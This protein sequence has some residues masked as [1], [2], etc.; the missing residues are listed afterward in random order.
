MNVIPKK[1][2]VR[3]E[4]WARYKYNLTTNIGENDARVT[5]SKEHIALSHKIAAEGMVLLENNGYLPLKPNT[6]V[7]LFG[8]G[9]LDYVKGGGGSGRVYPQ[10][11][12]NLYEG[13]KTKADR[14]SIYEP[15]S[16]Y[17]FDYLSPMA[18]AVTDDRDIVSDEIELPKELII[19]AAKNS[20]V[21]IISIHRFSREGFDRLSEKG[22]FY[23]TDTEQNLI[24]EVTTTFKHTIA[25]LNV[26]GM[27]DVSWLKG[28]PKIDAALLVWQAGMEGGLAIADI[29]CGDVNPS[30]KLT[31]TFAKSFADYPC[32]D[33]FHDSENYVSYYEDIF[34]GYRYFETIPNAEKKVN[35]PFGYGLS[36]TYFELTKPNAEI[37]GEK[38]KISL[39]VKNI[40][41][42]AGKEVVQ[43]Y[44]SAPQGNLGKSKIS[45]SGF[46]KTSLLA[47]GDTE[48]IEIQFNIS[49]MASFDDLGKLQK[50]AFLL[51]KGEYSFFAGNNCR[52][53]K[54]ADLI[55]KVKEDYIVTKQL[56]SKCAP[57]KLEKRMLSNGEFEKLPSFPI[58]DY[59]N[60][61]APINSAKAPD[62]EKPIMFSAVA[63]GKITLDEFICQLTDDELI[64]LMSGIKSLGVANTAG[65]GGIER[66]GIPAF[67]T[68]DG[69]AGVR[70][71][72]QVGIPTTA[73]PCATL[74]ACTWNTD[75]A[76]EMG[77][78]GALEAKEN[79]LA[80][81]LTPALNIHRNPLCG[82]NFE[83]FSEDPLVSGKFAAAKVK[84][85]QSV[86][87][88]ACIKH[89]A[90]NNKETNRK[91]SDSRVSERA[92]REIYMRGFEICIKEA[93]PW[94]L[95][96]SYNLINGRRCCTSYEQ[97]QGILRDE[98]G[99][100]GLVF[101]D[102][103]TP[104]EQKY[105]VISGNDVRMP[106]GDHEKLK[107]ALQNG[108]LSRSHF[109]L[110]A[111]RILELAMKFE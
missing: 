90:C 41:K 25:L 80:V 74:L 7:A 109:E 76:Y 31:D 65:I 108:E 45:L 13:F 17:Y 84:G 30:G 51:E 78:A 3:A 96:S 88:A 102:W 35:Y 77:K 58:K 12:R 48:N 10:Y 95:M 33:T 47:P 54:K 72:P 97:I 111:K 16:K 53:L 43:I 66:L 32:V 75:L 27:I 20:D 26:G 79:G 44:Y 21:A 23:L 100:K 105:C 86:N 55:F 68:T 71:E 60:V 91:L 42:M 99:Y 104:C 38:V 87:T 63:D 98:W 81:W 9:S 85:I 107:A 37:L 92:L 5:G 101:S 69:P 82:R 36:Y 93:D 15:L 22:D 83:Y 70:L 57:N 106:D 62:S 40:G 29:L 14:I 18:K 110:C 19:D 4:K 89:F 24:N 61:S 39:S 46:K 1:N 52:N 67:M 50:S 56:K 73:W 59:D 94:T 2:C 28:N 34:V 64:L 8:V 49:D 103:W 11:V 6:T